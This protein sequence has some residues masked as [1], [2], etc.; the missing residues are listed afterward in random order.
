MRSAMIGFLVGA[1]VVVLALLAFQQWVIRASVDDFDY[2]FAKY[3]F[4][5][6]QFPWGYLVDG[7]VIKRCLFPVA[8]TTH[9]YDAQYNEVTEADQPGRYGAVV[10]IAFLGGTVKYR[11]ITLYRTPELVHWGDGPATV[12]AQ[13]PPGIGVDPQVLAK[14]GVQIGN[15]IKWSFFG[16]GDV[17][18]DLAMILAGLHETSP[19]AP[20]AV[21][22]DYVESRDVA[23]WFGLRQ[24]LGLI[25]QYP[26]LVD[27]PEGY[28]A[29]P[30]KKWPLILFLHG[31]S[32]TGRDLSLL[33]QGGLPY[34]IAMGRKI[35]AIV[36]SPQTPAA[37]DWNARVLNLLLDDVIAKYRVDPDRVY[38]AGQSMGGDE[39]WEL[40]TLYPERF[41]AMVEIAGEGDPADVARLKDIPIWTFQGAKDVV[42]APINA[43]TMVDAVRKAGGHDHLTLFPDADHGQS[44]TLAFKTDALYT[45]L[46]AQKRGQPEVLTPGVP[47][48]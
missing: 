7:R 32:Q 38:V 24:R 34:E 2:H 21:L 26:H 44:W 4:S 3:V 33:R 48:P 18:P 43:T 45:W 15:A 13:L 35:P 29:D 14:Q 37:Q 17:S 42:V 39:A 22:R 1:L 9:F 41:A 23:W 10:K 25:E 5:E 20:P 11:Y 36:V 30:A 31:G 47:S 16:E 40:T 27:L 12:T 46:L 8:V 19:D 6:T 28:D